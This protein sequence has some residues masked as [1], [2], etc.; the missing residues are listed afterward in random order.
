FPLK[1]PVFFLREPPSRGFRADFRGVRASTPDTPGA[2]GAPFLTAGAVSPRGPRAPGVFL[3]EPRA[4]RVPHFQRPAGCRGRSRH[5]S[6][7]G[8]AVMRVFSR[9]S[10]FALAPLVSG[11]C[12]AV[13]LSAAGDGVSAV[14][15]F[16]AERL[17]DQSRRV[18]DALK[19]AAD[20]AWRALE[21]ALAGE[22]VRA[23]LDAADDKAVREQ[24]RLFVLNAPCG[25]GD[26]DFL[27]RF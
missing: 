20:R 4:D 12:R 17:S 14:A 10:L 11:A 22:S 27:P 23:A 9:L 21:F 26:R 15:R 16:L 18:A 2:T 7:P 3:D 13:G 8:G 1:Y 24:V 19:D 6:Y 5:F 25:R